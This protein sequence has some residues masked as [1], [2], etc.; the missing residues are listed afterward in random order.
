M[1][2][3]SV[4]ESKDREQLLAI[5]QALG[6]KS[7]S[8]AKKVDLIAKILEQT[9]VDVDVAAGET[10]ASA[11]APEARVNGHDASVADGET[12][13]AHERRRRE[14]FADRARSGRGDGRPAARRRAG[15]ARPRR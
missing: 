7:V 6:V 10:P 5:A 1:L 4:L 15:G 2:E 9:G 3:R 13:A 8:R 12:S 11:D 14:R